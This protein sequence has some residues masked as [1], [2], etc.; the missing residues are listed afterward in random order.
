MR[1][2]AVWISKKI[3]AVLL[4]IASIV[5]VIMAILPKALSKA[6]YDTLNSNRA[7]GSPLLNTENFNT[8][9]WNPWE[10]ICWGVFLSNFCK[11]LVDNYETA[12]DETSV[13]GSKGAGFRAL[14]GGSGSDAANKDV[15]RALTKYAIKMQGSVADQIYVKYKG[16]SY[17]P[18]YFQDLFF[19]PIMDECPSG[20]ACVLN[21]SIDLEG[22]DTAQENGHKHT[23]FR[24]AT[25]NAVDVT[26]E[27]K[28]GDGDPRYPRIINSNIENTNI[29]TFYVKREIA[30]A[31]NNE[32][33]GENN[34]ENNNEPT[35]EYVQILDYNHWW[36]VQ[37]I[38]QIANTMQ[39]NYDEF[40]QQMEY[41]WSTNSPLK[42]DFF[43]NIVTN[44]TS[45]SQ[46]STMIVIFPA[47]ANPNITQTKSINILNSWILNNY[48]SPVSK[49]QLLM[50]SQQLSLSDAMG[51]MVYSLD[52]TLDSDSI[53][54]FPAFSKKNSMLKISGDIGVFYYD[55]DTMLHCY[56]YGYGKMLNTL[57]SLDINNKETNLIFPIKFEVARDLESDRNKFWSTVFWQG[58]DTSIAGIL[59]T[60]AFASSTIVNFVDLSET[61]SI[62]TVFLNKIIMPNGE[63]LS[64]FDDEAI[65]I[66]VMLD[67]V[68][69]GAEAKVPTMNGKQRL[70]FNFLY[71]VARSNGQYGISP[72]ELYDILEE[73]RSLESVFSNFKS[74]TKIENSLNFAYPRYKD[75]ETFP[76]DTIG[77]R[78]RSRV[79][80][81]YPCN[82]V[83]RQASQVLGIKDGAEFTTY[84]TYIYMTYL[85]FYGVASAKDK[86][87]E[88]YDTSNFNEKIYGGRAIIADIAKTMKDYDLDF[89]DQIS[90]RDEVTNYG[91]LLLSPEGGRE[92]RKKLTESS[93]ADWM[94][95]QYNKTVYGG[96]SEFS[97]TSSKAKSGFLAIETLA[98]NW[99]T[100]AFVDNYADIAIWLIMGSLVAIL[101]IGLFKGKK[102][103]WFLMSIILMVNMVLLVPASGDIVPYV[104]SN[105]TQNMFRPKM[106]YWA[107]SQ[108]ITNQQAQQDA[109]KLA[110]ANELSNSEATQLSNLIGSLGSL[111]T[112]T[113]LSIKQDISQKVT[114]K[115]GA[116][117][118]QDIMSY[119]SARWILP[120]I[121][122]QFSAD[123]KSAKYIYKPLAN[124]W[125]D[126]SN[127][128]WYFDR[129]NAIYVNESCPTTTSGQG[130]DVVVSKFSEGENGT[131]VDIDD[132]IGNKAIKSEFGSFIEQSKKYSAKD[133]L[134]IDFRN[135]AYIEKDEG[136][137]K[138]TYSD[139]DSSSLVHRICYLLVNSSGE[140]IVSPGNT[141]D[142]NGIFGDRG[143]RYV[144]ADS[145]ENLLNYADQVKLSF[146]NVEKS[147][148]NSAA[149]YER[150]DRNTITDEMPYLWS[151]ESPMYYFFAVVK[152]SFPND[153]SLG[154]LANR[155]QGEVEQDETG[156]DL[157]YSF[158]HCTEE[159][160]NESRATGYIR[161]VL[162]LEEM[163]TNMI[164]YMYQMSIVANGFDGVSGIFGDAKISDKL[165]YYEGELQSWLFRCNWA[166]KIMENPSFSERTTVKDKDGKVYDIYNP[167][168]PQWYPDKR[169]MV[170]SEGQMHEMGLTEADLNLVELKCVEVN[171]QVARQWTLLINY[172][173]T[174]GITLEILMRQMATDATMIFCD[175]FSS[176]GILDTTYTIYPQSLDLRYL[177]FDSIM[178]MLMMN[179]SKDTS[180][181]Y[182]DT[183][184]TV[185]QSSDIFTA[186][187]LLIAAWLCAFLVPL[188][189]AILMAVIFYL[190]IWALIRGLFYTNK[191][192][193]NMACGQLVSTLLFMVYTLIYYGAFAI[194]T[195][196]V[197]ADEVLTV[198]SIKAESGSPA[199]VLLFVIL[200]SGVYMVVMFKHVKF[201]FENRADMG[202]EKFS[203][204][205]SGIAATVKDKASN[206]KSDVKN[207]FSR[208]DSESNSYS[209]SS[210]QSLKGTGSMRNSPAQS[211]I[212]SS[213]A[214]SSTSSSYSSD[215]SY[216]EGGG[217]EDTETT[218][219]VNRDDT[220]QSLDDRA[221]DYNA[222]F[223]FENS[224]AEIDNLESTD[225][226]EINAT[227]DTGEEIDDK[228]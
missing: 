161:D 224:E 220:R 152:D 54:G 34:D 104:A 59:S 91:Y 169:P 129:M 30:K 53:A 110:K 14:W 227:I 172:I 65:A 24:W 12:F 46:N 115:L 215:S 58:P 93:L 25:T 39:N 9:D 70:L 35:Y 2:R 228:S 221:G 165:P 195:A 119:Q 80:L 11:P 138:I 96:A 185:I 85:D 219:E 108:G 21:N 112:D 56:D 122:Q 222:N 52:P 43:G 125:E 13:F 60:T 101:I 7:L 77:V 173:S 187:L 105:I 141:S 225:T 79:I 42:L 36:D 83:M 97:G 40:Q 37:V 159:V 82:E 48:A 18:A 135:A 68:S 66:P 38:S 213:S 15:I 118:Y 23:A 62:E 177:S 84:C 136:N 211:N 76:L 137:S 111:Q 87:S 164:P 95:E 94:Y 218:V 126:L 113:S 143:E 197:S 158:M 146:E 130:T 63:E 207:M 19:Y 47:A 133:D 128:Y 100:S 140:N 144:D 168:I 49:T 147:I 194:M 214:S 1:S 99:F 153:C 64:L 131:V 109:L 88:K 69:V 78:K 206:L 132:A 41:F 98:D 45:G 180:Y 139:R 127:C 107:I 106:T 123:D 179:I 149:Q 4:V 181:I 67:A 124:V 114:Q 121:M 71:K 151:T 29:P 196:T 178:K 217:F 212:Y 117:V 81:A 103:S 208:E 148:E 183:M 182:G 102:F 191:V 44:G 216:A 163:F 145:W 26:N 17:R 189:R 162:D 157:R 175:E 75:T 192:K 167:L 204:L 155:L 171:K 8:E 188:F 170:F 50:G 203:A 209:T 184:L 160:G 226:E 6:S 27:W 174:P 57:F 200:L 32:N 223:S 86:D 154:T 5:S 73:K 74:S 210:T 193:G 190:G 176:S 33:T 16:N 20:D 92:Y 72:S 116:G 10:T 22:G 205:A 166:T 156:K 201:C 3:V 202:F 150:T 198:T 134:A 61:R 28:T 55:T 90:L 89:G 199:W 142:L 120:M 31:N 186:A 51:K